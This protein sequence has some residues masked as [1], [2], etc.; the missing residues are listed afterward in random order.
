MQTA[1]HSAV[2]TKQAR[3][4]DKDKIN[5]VI[6][7]VGIML[8]ITIA[9]QLISNYFYLDE[10]A[11]TIAGKETTLA[12]LKTE[13]SRLLDIQSNHSKLIVDSAKAENDY[14]EL[15]SL[16]PQ[17]AEQPQI[18]IW[19]SKEA[20]LR[21]LKLESFQE[22]SLPQNVQQKLG[23]LQQVS[24][25]AIVA[26]DQSQIA[27]LLVDFS[28]HERI[29]LVESVKLSEKEKNKDSTEVVTHKGEIV[30]SAFLGVD[31]GKLKLKQ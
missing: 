26:G 11:T 25:R 10:I 7:T 23:Q 8:T 14:R 24:I 13:N 17:K 30:F 19:L 20:A 4:T 12:G 22:N 18:L 28:R 29:L 16:I 3:Q 9:V 1:I 5:E 6:F 2:Q 27:K 31:N 15:Q 21:G